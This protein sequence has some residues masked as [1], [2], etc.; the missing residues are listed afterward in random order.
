MADTRKSEETVA[1]GFRRGEYQWRVGSIANLKERE[2]LQSKTFFAGGKKWA[3]SLL[4]WP[5]NCGLYNVVKVLLISRNS[6]GIGADVDIGVVNENKSHK[7]FKP[8]RKWKVATSYDIICRHDINI[9]HL[10]ETRELKPEDELMVTVGLKNIRDA[11][12]D[13][14][15][16]SRIDIRT[17]VL[18]VICK[19]SI[20]VW[21]NA[22]KFGLV[23]VKRTRH[24]DVK[25]CSLIRAWACSSDDRRCWLCERNEGGTLTVKSCMNDAEILDRFDDICED[26]N[27]GHPW[28]TVFTEQKNSDETFVPVDEDTLVVFCKS[29]DA[30]EDPSYLGC[31]HVKSTMQIQDLVTKIVTD[32]RQLPENTPYNAYVEKGGHCLDVT[33]CE[34]TLD[35]CEIVSGSVV[36]LTE[37]GFNMEKLCT[38]RKLQ[39][40]I[41]PSKSKA[42]STDTQNPAVATNTLDGS[43]S[44]ETPLD[45][46]ELGGHQET[47]EAGEDTATAE[48]IEQLSAF[49]LGPKS[50]IEDKASP[51][52]RS[53]S[54]MLPISGTNSNILDIK[55]LSLGEGT[56]INQE[57]LELPKHIQSDVKRREEQRRSRTT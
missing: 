20:E 13:E 21:L 24:S 8:G 18:E 17:V 57:T 12:Y 10:T 6:E 45:G 29:I 4:L 28:V 31:L 35:K 48:V 7:K 55:N 19:K 41:Q 32:L 16:E 49:A 26:D 40:V 9:D 56:L 3:L 23:D 33:S 37:K 51:P 11:S 22:N 2:G 1:V 14:Q 47:T 15:Q 50:E 34:A 43:R 44:I 36:I 27:G 42:P 54:K 46:D 30:N 5:H 52:K 25:N 39:P 53:S 38:V